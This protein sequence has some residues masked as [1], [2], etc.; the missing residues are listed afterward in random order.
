[1]DSVAQMDAERRRHVR[2]QLYRTQYFLRIGGHVYRT[3]EWSFG[4]FLIEDRV[5]RLTPGALLWIDGLISEDEYRRCAT[6]R[7]VDIRARA[8]RV[9]SKNKTV[10]LSCL[11]LDDIGFRILNGLPEIAEVSPAVPVG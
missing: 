5:G 4:G 3:L 10:A 6:P 2:T 1:M 11:Q 7:K 8:V 9:D